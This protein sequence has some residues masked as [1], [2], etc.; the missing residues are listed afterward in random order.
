MADTAKTLAPIGTAPLAA[1]TMKEAFVGSAGKKVE[2][3][4][5]RPQVKKL[6]DTSS[7]YIKIGLYG[8]PGMGKT[9]GLVDLIERYGLKILVV[10]TDVGGDGLS[11]VTAE[12]KSRGR[13]DLA[14]SHVYHVTLPTYEDFVE[15]TEKPELFFPEIYDA[16]IDVLVW[17]GY[18][19]FQQYQ[20]SEYVE[21]LDTIYDR[22]GKLITNKYWGEIRNASV[23][24]LNRFLYMHNRKTGQLWH[25]YVTLLVQDSAKEESLAAATSES[26]RQKLAKD[27]KTPF[28]QGSAAK[29][30]EPA[31]DFFALATTRKI[32]D[33]Q[34]AGKK[35][36]Q[37]VYK[38][39]PSERMKAKVRG[40][41][42]DPII[43]ANMGDVWAALVDAYLV[44][45][46]Q[47]SEEV[48][49]EVSA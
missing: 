34:N 9:F 25:K 22:E 33:P 19:G 46:G 10:S 31:F 1:P 21:T 45:P 40:V 23:K 7:R 2:T 18:S 49:E 3:K 28:V 44:Q 27:V 29:L 43:P 24:N 12:L 20:V 11:T 14:D 4:R 38:V 17:D 37:F 6:S 35:K 26:E 15:F 36:T 16:G 32:D 39:E 30:I 41:K 47:V 5:K 13:T 42:F 8:G 48:K